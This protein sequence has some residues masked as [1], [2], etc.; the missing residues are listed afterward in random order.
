MPR[1]FTCAAISLC[2]AFANGPQRAVWPAQAH[3][4]GRR[5]RCY[6]TSRRSREGADGRRAGRAP[7][8]GD[9]VRARGGVSAGPPLAQ[10]RRAALPE[11]TCGTAASDL[12][13]STGPRVL[14]CRYG[15][16]A[17]PCLGP[18]LFHP[19]L[20]P[21]VCS[22]NFTEGP[23]AHSCSTNSSSSRASRTPK[24]NLRDSAAGWPIGLGTS[25][26]KLHVSV[27]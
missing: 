1:Q 3:A 11:V 4:S 7:E 14:C 6:G 26:A 10:D 20:F 15:L 23:S 19:P 24:E 9:V 13:S 16:L 25:A 8:T 5:G 22:R 27:G 2:R 12:A 17:R 18:C 21:A